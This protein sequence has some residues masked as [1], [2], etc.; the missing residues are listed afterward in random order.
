MAATTVK[1]S[2]LVLCNSSVSVEQWYAQFR[3]WTQIGDEHITKFTA[4]N[5]QMPHP[6]ACVLISTYNM[7]SF[8]GRRSVEAEAIMK[9]IRE[10]EVRALPP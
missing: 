2:C 1:R 8:S 10:R 7:I 6:E 4:A 3:M 5:K 9:D